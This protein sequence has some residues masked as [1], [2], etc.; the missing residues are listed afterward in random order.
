M[1]KNIKINHALE[2]LIWL[3]II[4]LIVITI[5]IGKFHSEKYNKSYNIYVEDIN[6]LIIGSPVRMMGIQVGYVTKL[7]PVKDS[8]YI[9]FVLTHPDVY[10]PNGTKVAV[11]FNGLAGSRSLEIYP[12]DQT[13]YL[14]KETPMIEVMQT[15]RLRDVFAL[16]NE[17]YKKFSSIVYTTS[18]FGEKTKNIKIK[19]PENTGLKEFLIYSENF[20]KDTNQKFGVI[21]EDV[22]KLKVENYGK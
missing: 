21:K 2:L 11:E 17:M 12:P 14:S 19:K 8:V 6:G 20:M 16:F 1:M 5:T 3:L 22:L 18:S 7:K 4:L 13:T 10:L 15:K 9:K